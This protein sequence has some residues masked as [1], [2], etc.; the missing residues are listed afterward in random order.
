M[1]SINRLFQDIPVIHGLINGDLEITGITIDSRHV[2]PG[3]LF[4][5][6][7]GFEVDG[8]DFVD[9]AIQKGAGVLVVEHDTGEKSIPVIRVGNTRQTVALLANRYYGEPAEG[10]Q[11]LGITGT[12]GKSTVAFLLESV[13]ANAGLEVGL[14]GTL[15]YQWKGKKE[16]AGR[17]TPDSIEL[18]HLLRKMNDDGVRCVVMEVS[19]HALALDRI[20]GIQYNTAVFTNLSRDHLDFHSSMEEYGRCKAKLFEML[21]DEGCGVVNGDDPAVDRIVEMARGKIVRYGEESTKLDYKIESIQHSAGK[22]HFIMRHNKKTIPVETHLRGRFNIMNCA[23]AAICGL[24]MGL[25]ESLVREGISRIRTVRGR[26]ETIQSIEGFKVVIDYAH[27]PE[28]L[29]NVLTATREFTENQLILVFGCGGDRDR[30]K[31]PEMGSIAV[32]YADVI[33]VTSDNPRREN[34]EVI[35]RDILDGIE[36]NKKVVSISDRRAAIHAALD[37]AKPGDVVLIAG[38][39]HETYQEV[40]TQRCPFDDREV[41]ENHLKR[42]NGE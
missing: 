36:I 26:M 27:T 35:I 11:I 24:E 19:S 34:P 14:M 41:V 1:T 5:A 39:G 16:T 40:G 33:F 7:S 8:H 18:F 29:Y 2:K 13:L 28:A 42:M 21:S 6:I 37:E 3:N 17:T 32:D 25:D 30:G 20:L 31:R 23:A 22:N 38:K 9:D 12:N 10:L 15:V 4:V